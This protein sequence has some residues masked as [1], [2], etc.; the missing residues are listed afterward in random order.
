VAAVELDGNG[1]LQELHWNDKAPVSLLLHHYAL[2]SLHRAVR[3]ADSLAFVQEGMRGS[4][5]AGSKDGANCLNFF[6]RD[7]RGVMAESNDGDY[8]GR[9]ENGQTVPVVEPAEN[10][11]GEKGKIN[12]NEAVGATSSDL[13]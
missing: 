13:V 5:K 1:A 2:N 3:N 11:A 6:V 12:S 9:G 7:W 4:G 10:I 8:A